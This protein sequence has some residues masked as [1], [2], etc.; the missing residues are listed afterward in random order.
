MLLAA[1]VCLPAAA[2]QPAQAGV[3]RTETECRAYRVR[4]ETGKDPGGWVASCRVELV[5]PG[6]AEGEAERRETI[7]HAYLPLA[8][9][10]MR[11]EALAA[12]D[13]FL[14]ERV[15]EIV[16]RHRCARHTEELRK[17]KN[18]PER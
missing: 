18:K 15:K 4:P 16:K 17:G 9:P 3:A 6:N 7:W 14:D 1:M 2:Q 8:R 13:R 10:A 11:K 5:E 12:V